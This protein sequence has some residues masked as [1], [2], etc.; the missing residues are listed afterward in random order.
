MHTQQI[1]PG[2]QTSWK[3]C[4]DAPDLIPSQPAKGK[5]PP[6]QDTHNSIKTSFWMSKKL[7]I[8]WQVRSGDPPFPFCFKPSQSTMGREPSGWQHC[9]QGHAPWACC[10]LGSP[11]GE[12]IWHL[13]RSKAVAAASSSALDILPAD[14]L[15]ECNN[16]CQREFF[17]G[18]K[19]LILIS[20]HLKLSRFHAFCPSLFV[21]M[22]L[23]QSLTQI[24]SI[25][26]LL[27]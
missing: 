3:H 23:F 9:L 20:L 5:N 6:W 13:P 26:C 8:I 14:S 4:S 17:P 19:H 2:Q 27:L 15:P 22:L 10:C 7:K 25:T 24:H 12:Q 16:N 11:R 1:H 21:D 18:G